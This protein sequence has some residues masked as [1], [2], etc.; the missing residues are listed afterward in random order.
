MISLTNL[1]QRR[2][3]IVHPNTLSLLALPGRWQV[4]CGWNFVD[5]QKPAPPHPLLPPATPW[6]YT[7]ELS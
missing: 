1:L 3:L 7:L 4:R 5:E 6:I 2:R